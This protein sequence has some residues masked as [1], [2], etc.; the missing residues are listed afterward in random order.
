MNNEEK[1]KTYK[2]FEAFIVSPMTAP[3]AV[4]GF[5]RF[6]DKKMTAEEAMEFCSKVK[7]NIEQAAK[8]KEQENKEM[9]KDIVK[10]VMKFLVNEYPA[11]VQMFKTRNISGDSMENVYSKFGVTIDYAF[12]YDYIEIFGLH[13]N[14]FKFVQRSWDRSRNETLDKNWLEKLEAEK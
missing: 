5:C 8:I 7:T 12:G 11:G 14:E 10:E 2:Y 3:Y 4:S 13:E 9:R 6:S 1:L